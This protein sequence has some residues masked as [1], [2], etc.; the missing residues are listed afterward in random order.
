VNVGETVVATVGITITAEQSMSWWRVRKECRRKR[1]MMNTLCD[2]R[3]QS[4]QDANTD[5]GKSQKTDGRYR[6]L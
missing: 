2:K 4:H 3:T 1:L 5:W 6:K